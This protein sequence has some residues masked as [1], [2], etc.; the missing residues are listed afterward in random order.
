MLPLYLLPHNFSWLF[1]HWQ[2]PRMSSCS[3]GSYCVEH[4]PDELS[5]S[6][7]LPTFVWGG[8]C[9]LCFTSLSFHSSLCSALTS[10]GG[11]CGCGTQGWTGRAGGCLS[12]LRMVWWIGTCCCYKLLPWLCHHHWMKFWESKPALT[13]VAVALWSPM[14]A[15]PIGQWLTGLGR[16]GKFAVGKVMIEVCNATLQTL[17]QRLPLQRGTAKLSV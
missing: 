15:V 11:Y 12:A 6:C 10:T 9:G 1:C 8:R 4:T 17:F 16:E 7:S 14:I 5:P 2:K 13:G 3:C